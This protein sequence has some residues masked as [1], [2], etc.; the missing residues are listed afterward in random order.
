MKYTTLI[1]LAS[2]L[3]AANVSLNANEGLGN[4]RDVLDKWVETKQIISEE[5][6]NWRTEKSILGD[7]LVLLKNELE[8]LD[9]ALEDLESSA[10]AADEE[11]AALTG[12]KDSLN[13]ASETITSKLGALETALKQIVTKLPEPLVSKI[14]PLVRRL[15]ENPMETNLSLGERVQNIVGILSQTDKFNTTV[16]MTSESREID[17]GK[18]IEVRTLY[19]G[20]AMAYYVDQSGT[21]A[22]IGFPG[23]EGW[24]WPKVEGAGPEIKKLLD[25]YEGSEEIQFVTVPAKIN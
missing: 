6:S 3:L 13:T 10:T 17:G 5:S 22:G 9:S 15:P 18:V 23:A 8:R 4:T 12:E 16:T 21:Y 25:V 20:L 2:M 14:K 1:S 11:R 7:T 24:E 19:W